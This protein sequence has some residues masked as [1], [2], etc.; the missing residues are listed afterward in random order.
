[1]LENLEMK[2]GKS[3]YWQART[4]IE[5]DESHFWNRL[6]NYISARKRYTKGYQR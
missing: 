2:R 4:I 5:S 6:S 3:E 1:V